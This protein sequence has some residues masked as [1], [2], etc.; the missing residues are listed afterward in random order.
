M[1]LKS[2]ALARNKHRSGLYKV[3]ARPTRKA[4]ILLTKT[5]DFAGSTQ[6][7][8]RGCHSIQ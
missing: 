7:F 3:V 2:S 8:F 5:V 1:L 4:A 6:H